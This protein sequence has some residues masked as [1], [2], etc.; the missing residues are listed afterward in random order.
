MAPEFINT[1]CFTLA[2]DVWSF[3]VV[4]WEMFSFGKEPYGLEADKDVIEKLRNGYKLP[5]PEE[6]IEVRKM[7]RVINII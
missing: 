2:S 7:L 1:R 6:M 4:L 5:C 3:G